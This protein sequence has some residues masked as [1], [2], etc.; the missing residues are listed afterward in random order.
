MSTYLWVNMD[1]DLCGVVL[2]TYKKTQEKPVKPDR[3]GLFCRKK[4]LKI[5]INGM[6]YFL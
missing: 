2:I 1:F 3:E 5:D 6:Y 4:Y